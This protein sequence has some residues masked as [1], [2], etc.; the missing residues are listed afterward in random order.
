VTVTYSVPQHWDGG[1]QG[2]LTI[3][4]HG[5]SALNGWQI[6]ITLPG[7][8]VDT[9][10]NAQWQAGGGATLTMTPASYD[11]VLEPG[12]SQSVNFVAKGNTTNP[13]NCTFDGSACR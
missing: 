11:Q 12:T 7:D 9:V 5:H 8:E 1:F 13:V 6:V 4:D 10:W 3:V 2:Q